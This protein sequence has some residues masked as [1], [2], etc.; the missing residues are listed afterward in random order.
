MSG[1]GPLHGYRI[2]DVT[3]MISGPLATQILADQG[4]DVV[5]VEN[6]DGGDYTR[7]VPNRGGGLSAAF[8]NNNRNKR[9]VSINLKLE[10]GRSAVMRLVSRADV[11]VQNF[12]PG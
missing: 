2:I 7:A 9:S 4:A 8:L 11:F 3:S 10:R 1:R 12:R 6:P 5:K